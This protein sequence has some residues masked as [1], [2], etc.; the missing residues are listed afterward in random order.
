MGGGGGGRGRGG[1]GGLNISEEMKGIVIRC[2]GEFGLEGQVGTQKW[3]QLERLVVRSGS[4][5]REGD[6]PNQKWC[7][8][9]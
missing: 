4:E 5:G 6:L 3:L 7:T 9:V 1:K 8:I 2:K